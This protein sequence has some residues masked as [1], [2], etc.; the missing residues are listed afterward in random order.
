MRVSED[1]IFC[2]IIAGQIPCTKVYE[3]DRAL[4]FMDVSPLNKGHLLVV[5]KEHFGNVVEIDPELY[6]RLY[7][8]VCKMAKAVQASVG[9]EGMNVMQLNGMA[10]NQ[11]VPHLHIHLVPRWTGDGLTICAWEPA[12]GNKE[13]IAA[14]AEEIKSKI[15]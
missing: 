3:D 15:T 8:L 13:D 5:P 6:G 10:G 1:C 14:A 4:V 11:V 7:S 9:P 12:L 2:K